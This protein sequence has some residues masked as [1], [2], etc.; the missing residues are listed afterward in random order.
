MV[1]DFTSEACPQGDALRA[2]FD[3]VGRPSVVAVGTFDGVHHGHRALLR[4]ARRIADRRGL[5]V[6]AVTFSPRPEQVFSPGQALPDICP[7]PERVTRLRRAG[8]DEVVVVPFDR[9]V[10]AVDYRHVADL[11]VECLGM[12]VLV[13]GEDFA[14][15]HL[16]L[17]TPDRLRGLGLEV[18]TQRLVVNLLGTA[19]ASSSAVR[20]AVAAGI[21]PDE[22][23]AMG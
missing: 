10:A 5:D 4:T 16:R 3:A 12:Q 13:V 21:D 18:V 20:R 14:F 8:A 17:G 9:S 6:I 2:L 19:K 11:L 23:L 22:A 1:A 15:G 7:V